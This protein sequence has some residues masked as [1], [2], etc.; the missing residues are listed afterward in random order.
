[1]TYQQVDNTR[2]PTNIIFIP[3]NVILLLSR[4]STETAVSI[5]KPELD[6][7][8]GKQLF[9]FVF[10]WRFQ[11][12]L[13]ANEMPIPFHKRR[14][15]CPGLRG[16]NTVIAGLNAPPLVPNSMWSQTA[17]NI[18]SVVLTSWRWSNRTCKNG[19]FHIALTM[20]GQNIGSLT[21]TRLKD[22]S[23]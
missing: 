20:K 15:N 21:K 5:F 22:L 4:A 2:V 19:D 9:V 12:F 7:F 6:G 13:P 11:A 23:P 17:L 1:M 16:L 14:S 10:L 3:S 8:G 18:S